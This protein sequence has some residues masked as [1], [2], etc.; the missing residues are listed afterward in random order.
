MTTKFIAHFLPTRKAHKTRTV[1][2]PL[3]VNLFFGLYLV[4]CAIDEPEDTGN[5]P[6]V[7]KSVKLTTNAVNTVMDKYHKTFD[8]YTDQT[9]PSGVLKHQGISARK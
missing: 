4:S 8:V 5:F 7:T 6:G 9:C 3:T 1:L 2:L